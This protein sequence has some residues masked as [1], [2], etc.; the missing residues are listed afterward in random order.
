MQMEVCQVVDHKASGN[1]H[2]GREPVGES[3]GSLVLLE[4]RGNGAEVM[5]GQLSK[6]WRELQDV[7]V[8]QKKVITM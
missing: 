8:Y 7:S 3:P 5:L 2:T 1:T 6:D 4:L